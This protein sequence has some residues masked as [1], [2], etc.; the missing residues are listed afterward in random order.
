MRILDKRFV[1]AAHARDLPIQA[2]TIND[3]DQM[4][5]LLNI[6]VDAIMTDEAEVLK[7]VML[8]RGVWHE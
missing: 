4:H 1:R 7:A 6:G 8:E 5:H 3:R 2:W